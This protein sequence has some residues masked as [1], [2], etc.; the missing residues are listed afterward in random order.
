MGIAF[1]IIFALSLQLH[2]CKTE[3]AES[4]ATIERHAP[5]FV[6]EVRHG[7]ADRAA[8]ALRAMDAALAPQPQA[9]ALTIDERLSIIS[10]RTTAVVE[11][12]KQ[13]QKQKKGAAK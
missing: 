13:K 7:D 4:I 2:D 6:N 8:A 11:Q 5:N 1:V 9:Q 3:I 12:Q 10:D